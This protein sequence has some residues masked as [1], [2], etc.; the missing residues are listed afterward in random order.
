MNE[1]IRQI[2]NDDDLI[3]V[4]KDKETKIEGNNEKKINELIKILKNNDDFEQKKNF[5]QNKLT[6]IYIF[7]KKK[8]L[9]YFIISFIVLGFNW[10]MMTSFCAIFKNTGT[11]LILNSFISLFAS[12]IHPFILGLIPTIFGFL[13]IK[14]KPKSKTDLIEEDRGKVNKILY[15]I[16]NIFNIF[17]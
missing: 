15:K 16:Y 10:Y 6:S 5:R 17:L 9:I 13:A 1:M 12:F 11:K 2:Q 8:V 14:I 4:I 3:D 7:Y